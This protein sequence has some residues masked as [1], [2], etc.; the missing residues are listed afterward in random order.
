VELRYY[1]REMSE[2]FVEDLEAGGK[3]GLIVG[4]TG[5]GKA[6]VLADVAKLYLAKHGKPVLIIAH[7]KRLIK[8]LSLTLESWC[9][10]YVSVEM[11][12]Q[13]AHDTLAR[14]TV[15]SVQSLAKESRR[16]RYH[17]ERFGLVV[18]DEGHHA[19]SAGHMLVLDHF[20]N[21][22]RLLFT[23][24][25]DV[26]EKKS[27]PASKIL[28]DYPLSKAVKE[29]YLCPIEAELI[30]LRI[31]LT[32]VHTKMGDFKDSE[33][34]TALVPYLE[35][36]AKEIVSRPNEKHLVFTP[37]IATSKMIADILNGMGMKTLHLDGTSVNPDKGISAF[38]RG[39]YQCMTNSM[40]MTEGYDIP[41]VSCITNLRATKSRTLYSQIIGR[42]TRLYG[43]KTRLLLLDFLWHTKRHKLCRPANLVAE[44][45]RVQEIMESTYRTG[46]KLNVIEAHDIA[47][48]AVADQEKSI[49]KEIRSHEHKKR[50]LINPLTMTEYDVDQYKPCAD[51][52]RLD[53]TP[54]QL[55]T[56]KK[57]GVNTDGMTRGL[58][59]HL[60]SKIR[61]STDATPAQRKM[62][63]A[64]GKWYPNMSKEEAS[65]II[66]AKIGSYRR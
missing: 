18:V 63:M 8:Q 43:G 65:R 58:A 26:D 27:L 6:L 23:A 66:D 7:R 31:D 53:I 57:Q 16:K 49:V 13:T 32:K 47:E 21:A 1:Q 4:A 40:L 22:Y 51:W 10:E 54:A 2:S 33:L 30:P 29:G 5:A 14:I 17:A 25:P 62:L 37:L 45:D 35:R 11:A 56:L 59:H 42:G 48:R 24:T 44:S 39:E 34:D 9:N 38:E 46:G 36:I 28:Y 50:E 61:G 15:A 12:E 41:C 55:D 60:I 20:P 19:G 3:A 52:E 64:W